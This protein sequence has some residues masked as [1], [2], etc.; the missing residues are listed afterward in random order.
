MDVW[1]TNNL[2]DRR[3][4]DKTFRRQTLGRHGWA[5]KRL[6]DRRLGDILADK[7]SERIITQ[8]LY[9]NTHNVT[10]TTCNYM[11]KEN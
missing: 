5:T 6:G 8:T 11:Y 9:N 2:G 3:L 7:T 4:G 1:A 10:K